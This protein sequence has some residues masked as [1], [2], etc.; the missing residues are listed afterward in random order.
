MSIKAIR[1]AV[2]NG[3]RVT[4]PPP[5]QVGI[6]ESPDCENIDPSDFR[7]A[8]TRPGSSQFGSNFAA[9]SGGSSNGLFHW[10]RNAGTA[11]MLA[12]H[13]G[14]LYQVYSN[15]WGSLLGG[16]TAGGMVRF[17]GL[18]NQLVVAAEGLTPRIS[19]DASGFGTFSDANAPTLAK[20]AAVWKSKMWLAGHSTTPQKI[21]FSASNDP[22]DYTTAN[23][24]GSIT[25]ESGDGDVIN[26]LLAMQNVLYVFKRKVVYGIFGSSPFDFE[27]IR[28]REVG[29]SSE[30]GYAAGDGIAFFVSDD[31]IYSLSGGNVGI[32]TIP[33]AYQDFVDLTDKTKIALGVSGAKLFITDYSN[34]SPYSLVLDYK[35]GVWSKYP[36]QP[37]TPY[38]KSRDSKIYAVTNASTMQ[39]W[40]LDTGS[41]GSID[42]KWTTPDMDFEDP[43]AVKV[44]QQYQAH[45]KPDTA[46]TT[47]TVRHYLN[48]ASTG[49]DNTLTFGT[50]GSHDVQRVHGQTLKG[51][52][53]RLRFSW[54]GVK[55]LYGFT[56][57]ADVRQ[58]GVPGRDD[59]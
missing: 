4:G 20:Y 34:A 19:S 47:L 18:N 54:T 35:R 30:Y 11:F 55:T 41:G 59:D 12:A 44:L 52:F 26:G 39:V 46:T 45:M 6:L 23:N 24:A 2:L 58:E 3:G 31:G 56:I 57:F 49:S 7:G 8:S 28:L 33:K 37:F 40:Q 5:H 43:S 16:I 14:T 15:S 22:T 9:A 17:G 1:A 27:V 42:C 50:V 32:V 21:W 38:A 13:S 10:T 25:V 29:L 48:G 51:R 53:L 36:T